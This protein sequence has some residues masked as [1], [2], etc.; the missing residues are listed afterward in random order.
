MFKYLGAA[1]TGALLLVAS[2][3]TSATLLTGGF[4]VVG[5]MTPSDDPFVIGSTATLGP[6][7]LVVSAN[8]DYAGLAGLTPV[9]L[10]AT[11]FT[12][13]MPANAGLTFSVGAFTVKVLQTTSAVVGGPFG[14]VTASVILTGP[15]FDA[16]TGILS[17]AA[18]NLEDGYTLGIQSTNMAPVPLPAALPLMVGAI[19]LLGLAR[20]R[21]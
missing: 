17:L 8:G 13:D 20:K 16:T 21:V 19:G 4:N 7:G 15:G 18:N 3:A 11:T 5:N 2:A 6:S 9:N 14:L 1:L 12:I 10:S